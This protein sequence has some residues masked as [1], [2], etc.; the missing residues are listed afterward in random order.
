ML[1]LN[2]RGLIYEDIHLLSILKIQH[3]DIAIIIQ[4]KRNFRDTLDLSE[5][6]LKDSGFCSPVM[7]PVP[8][9]KTIMQLYYGI[10]YR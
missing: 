6:T 9:E 4:T 2:V 7:Q 8:G 5:P 3:I 10:L 1:T